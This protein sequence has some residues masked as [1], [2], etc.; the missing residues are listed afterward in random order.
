[1]NSNGTTVTCEKWSLEQET[2][3]ISKHASIRCQQ[4][5]LRPQDVR[6]ITLHSD[7]SIPRG[8]GVELVRISKTKLSR[9]GNRTPEGVAVDRLKNTCL[10]LAVD[11]TVITAI[12]LRRGKYRRGKVRRRAA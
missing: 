8:S 1:M 11:N 12:H 10:L 4:R 9:M 6:A 7:I 3:Q 5:G 2:F